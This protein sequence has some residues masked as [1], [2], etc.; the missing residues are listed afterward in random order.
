MRSPYFGVARLYF[1]RMSVSTVAEV[2]PSYASCAK[3]ASARKGAKTQYSESSPAFPSELKSNLAFPRARRNLHRSLR[4]QRFHWGTPASMLP[5]A[6]GNDS[7]KMLAASEESNQTRLRHQPAA[8][9]PAYRQ[10][11]QQP[12]AHQERSMTESCRCFG[13]SI[14]QQSQPTRVEPTRPLSLLDAL[15]RPPTSPKTPE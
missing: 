4:T 8:T 6:S 11:R 15:D 10:T 1:S 3:R 5:F 9:H 12:F 13:R 2:Q 14:R 7:S